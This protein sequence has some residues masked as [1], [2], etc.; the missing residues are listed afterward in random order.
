MAIILM[1]HLF[2]SLPFNLVIEVGKVQE[3]I[4]KILLIVSNLFIVHLAVHKLYTIKI[5]V[6]AILGSPCLMVF[7]HL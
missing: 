7:R 4:I 1:S 5:I 3:D 6:S 2:L